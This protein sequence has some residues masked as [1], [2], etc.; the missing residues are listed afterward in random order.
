MRPMF[1]TYQE[2]LEWITKLM[3]LHGIKPGLERTEALLERL[4]YPHRRLKFI[5]VAGTN[6]KGSTCAFLA[7]VLRGAGYD[8]GVFTSP[9]L[10][11]YTNRIQ[12]NDEDI[13][14]ASVLAI[15][16][17]IKPISDEIEPLHGA[18]SMFEI[19]TAIAI[20]YFATEAYPDFV[21]WETGMGGRL[22]STNVVAPIVSVITN[23]G[24]DHTDVLGETIPQIAREK[25]GII[26]PGVPVVSTATQPEAAAV[27]RETA[28]A[29]K[30]SLYE[31]GANFRYDTREVQEGRQTF[32]F[33]GPFRK[34]ENVAIGMDGLH[35]QTNAALA[36]M[37]IEV[38]R[39]Y[40]ALV[41]DDEELYAGFERARWK[42]RLEMVSRAPRILLD[43][44]N[45]PDGAKT[46]ADTLK[47]VYSYRRLVFVL[48]M[49]RNKNHP[50]YLRHILPIV[51]TLIVTEPDFFK[52]MPAGELASAA[53]AWREANGA[54]LSI[55]A[56]PDWRE[57]L[58]RARRSAGPDDLIV[59]SGSL[60]FLSDARAR[61]L[62]LADS[63]KGW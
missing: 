34:L 5:H 19:S 35:Q 59:V 45:N 24:L 2:A 40:Y 39:Q 31:L 53:E 26:K 57:A 47:Q 15:A 54:S 61:V 37:T 50:E 36:L 55:A 20:V 28:V 9:F 63:E 14:E 18:L 32:D 8:V 62:N 46:L 51:D 49:L 11:K 44:A 60:Y 1:Q 3:P 10:E 52:A 42:G 22:D 58:E 13:P 38:L 16:N 33:E 6:G 41:V 7:S 48:G 21:V 12:M 43:G 25:A 30:A 23:V 17:R 29:R 4:G 27:I 56:E